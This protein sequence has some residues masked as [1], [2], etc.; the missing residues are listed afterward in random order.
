ME[1]KLPNQN[2]QRPLTRYDG[3]IPKYDYLGKS[4]GINSPCDVC[5]KLQR[6]S[7]YGVDTRSAVGQ[8]PGLVGEIRCPARMVLGSW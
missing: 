7:S 4:H 8:I 5:T 1:G 2:S 6:Q 3:W